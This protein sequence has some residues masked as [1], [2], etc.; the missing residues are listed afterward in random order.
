[1]LVVSFFHLV[2]NHS[3]NNK[4]FCL[5]C[6]FSTISKKRASR[7]VPVVRIRNPSESHKEALMKHPGS[8]KGKKRSLTWK[9]LLSNDYLIEIRHLLNQIS[10]ILLVFEVKTIST[11]NFTTV[12]T[13]SFKAHFKLTKDIARELDYNRLTVN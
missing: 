10:L 9:I 3:S 4:V 7:G 1:M 2:L 12:S 5:H 6:S 11:R 8:G 13:F